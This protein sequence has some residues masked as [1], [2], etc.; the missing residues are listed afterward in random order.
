M[1]LGGGSIGSGIGD[2]KVAQPIGALTPGTAYRFHAIA[3]DE[4]GREAI[5]PDS[6]FLTY[7]PA[8]QGLPDARAYEQASPLD[9]NG[10]NVEGGTNAVQAAAN[11]NAITFFASSGLPGGEGAQNFPIYLAQRSSAPAWST[12]GLLPPAATGPAGR[13]LGW[14]DDLLWAYS[15]NFFPGEPGRDRKSVV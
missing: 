9:K 3:T 6:H 5:G 4:A 2:V 15:G 11:G 8:N 12:Q 13:T 7:T 10:A 14:S 1:P